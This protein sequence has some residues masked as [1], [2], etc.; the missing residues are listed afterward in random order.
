M[1]NHTGVPH[2]CNAQFFDT[3][4]CGFIDVV[5]FAD[6]VFFEGAV[7]FIRCF[8]IAEQTRHHLIDDQ[9][10]GAVRF[11]KHSVGDFFLRCRTAD[12]KGSK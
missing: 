11:R 1:F 6:S 7:F 2:V 9:F 10:F 5:E 3:L 4:Q 8:G 12:E